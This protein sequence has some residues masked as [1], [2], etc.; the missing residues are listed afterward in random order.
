MFLAFCSQPIAEI[1]PLGKQSCQKIS[2]T[3]GPED[4]ELIRL[5]NQTQMIISSHDRRNF[6]SNGKLYKI[7]LESHLLA[8]S[9]FNSSYL[10]EPLHV[11][12]YPENFKPH[13]ISSSYK[14]GKLRLYVISHPNLK[15]KKNTIEI[16]ELG[17]EKTFSWKYM[18]E[19]VNEKLSHPNDLY[20]LPEERLLI[21]NDGDSVNAFLFFIN[22]IFK[23]ATAEITYYENGKYYIADEKVPFGNG[24]YYEE[25]ESEKRL[26][27]SS[28]LDKS[29]YVYDVKWIENYQP[30]LT[31]QFKIPFD[32]GPD[33]IMKNEYGFYVATHPSNLAFL[34]HVKSAEN[35]APS[36]I[37]KI[38]K[39]TNTKLIYS[40]EGKEISAASTAVAYKNKLFIAQVFEDFILACEI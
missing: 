13:G 3:P 35:Y 10:V 6:D 27:R 7:N 11:D 18:G 34:N 31:L 26:Y 20:A 21:S 40:N 16:F 24:I 38:E 23:R 39:L 15:E 32:G 33:N 9:K 30:M 37:Y 8:K 14:N 5:K 29:I 12:R 25:I 4:F 17:N 19:L 1:R 36:M 22:F 28:H 2:R